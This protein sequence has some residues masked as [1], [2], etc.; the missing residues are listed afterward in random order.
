[1]NLRTTRML[2]G[3]AAFALLGA[4]SACAPKAEEPAPPPPPPVPSELRIG[5]SPDYPP[6]ALKKDGKLQGIEVDLGNKLADEL[7]VRVKFVELKWE[8]L[9]PALRGGRIDVIMSGMSVT[10]D[11][12]RLVSFTQPF[13]H[14]GQMA[15]I[16]KADQK[17]F[18][19]EGALDRPKVRIGFHND[20]TGEAF[21][22]DTMKKAKLVGF[23]SIDKGIAALR[24]K[25]IDVFVHD[26]P[27]IWRITGGFG[28]KEKQLAG[29]FEL[30]TDEALAWAVRTEDGELRERLSA[31]LARWKAD[32]QLDRVLDRWIPV[33]KETVPLR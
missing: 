32:G 19:E 4:L 11:R 9:I 8:D 29:R 14:V 24:R 22:R 23:A 28:S 6:L 17:K 16:R 21:V 18:R 33:R 25:K 12:R 2:A 7:K 1:M 10:E 26:A 15:L 30:L 13:L 5:I 20:T 27:T 3:A 31:A